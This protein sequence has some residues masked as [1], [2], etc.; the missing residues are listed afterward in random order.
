VLLSFFWPGLDQLRRRRRA[1]GLALAVPQAVLITGAGIAWV[2][3]P[4]TV[5]RWLLEPAFLIGILGL[6]L[7][8]LAT[9]LVA[10]GEAFVRVPHPPSR[11]A[12]TASAAL[13]A[14]SS[15][16]ASASM[17]RLARSCGRDMT[18]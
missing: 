14:C 2:S 1:L 16:S 3:G 17:G 9:R 6:D 13:L 8:I 10:M 7:V 12:R 15:P 5:M 18:R 4:A 11:A